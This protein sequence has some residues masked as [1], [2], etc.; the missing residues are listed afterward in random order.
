MHVVQRQYERLLCYEEETALD[1]RK[2]YNILDF[3]K[4][5]CS[6]VGFCIF[7]VTFLS[8]QKNKLSNSVTCSEN[9]VQCLYECT[10]LPLFFV[11]PCVFLKL[12]SPQA[13]IEAGQRLAALGVR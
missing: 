12:S 2:E 13:S 11:V 5:N 6:V 3:N 4:V 9:P 10:K 1:V 7:Y 8:R